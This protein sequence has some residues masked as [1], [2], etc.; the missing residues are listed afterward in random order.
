MAHEV[1]V[2]GF[3]TIL[4]PYWVEVDDF[5]V[6]NAFS[7]GLDASAATVV[8]CINLHLRSV[9]YH[10]QSWRALLRVRAWSSWTRS[11]SSSS[12]PLSHRNAGARS[13]GTLAQARQPHAL[14]LARAASTASRQ[15][16]SSSEETSA[17]LV[18][19]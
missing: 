19:L 16:E 14:A 11:M 7:T 2:C 13:H 18:L 8:T 10:N 15:D 3:G 9:M 5:F 6:Y 4:S 12:G 17:M 1:R